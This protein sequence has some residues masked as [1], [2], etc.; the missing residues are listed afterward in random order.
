MIKE[1]AWNTFKNTGNINSFL[2]LVEVENVQKDMDITKDKVNGI[3]IMNN[4][5]INVK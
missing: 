2:E 1:I 3:N 5:K 4:T